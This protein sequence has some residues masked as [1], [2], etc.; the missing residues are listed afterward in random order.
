M[1]FSEVAYCRSLIKH[2][3][4]DSKREIYEEIIK[5][6]KLSLLQ[7]TQAFASVFFQ[8]F[9]LLVFSVASYHRE[10]RGG[11]KEWMNDSEKTSCCFDL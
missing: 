8:A 9:C 4:I 2:N 10:T 6:S 1:V 11:L 7:P 5:Y 3:V